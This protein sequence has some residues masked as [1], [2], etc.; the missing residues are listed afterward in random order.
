MA[1]S[2]DKRTAFIHFSASAGNA[3]AIKCMEHY[4]T[5]IDSATGK[6]THGG[7]KDLIALGRLT[8]A[9]NLCVAAMVHEL[10]NV[11]ESYRPDEG[12][13]ALEAAV[14]Y[15]AAQDKVDDILKQ[16][17]GCIRAVLSKRHVDAFMEKLKA[18]DKARDGAK[19]W[20]DKVL[21]NVGNTGKGN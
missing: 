8:H 3:A 20:L 1:T 13:G 15:N 11:I 2:D 7:D 12:V 10:L 14:H 9:M 21:H 19:E 4:E 5:T 16:M 18:V 17:D 6:A